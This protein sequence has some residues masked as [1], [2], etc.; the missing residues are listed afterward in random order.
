MKV[1]IQEDKDNQ[2]VFIITEDK[3]EVKKAIDKVVGDAI[4]N[5]S[6]E[7]F[8]KGKAP[9]KVALSKLDQSKVLNESVNLLLPELY[10]Q[11]IIELKLKPITDPKIELIKFSENDGLEVAVTVAEKP[12]ID[13]KN[14]KA[15]I[16]KYIPAIAPVKVANDKTPEQSEEEKKQELRAGILQELVKGSDIKLAG[17]LIEQETARMLNKLATSL[18]KMNINLEDYLKSQNKKVE[19]IRKE[20]EIVAEQNLKSEFILNAIG[21]E[22]EIK[23]EDSEITDEISSAPDENTKKELE[24]PENRWYIEGV[25]FTRKVFDKIEQLYNE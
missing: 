15:T 18:N 19:D 6:V 22:L 24:K 14:Y 25:I 17:L 12:E 8:R 1:N 11:A 20:Y 13:L 21:Q 9:K 10:K 2:K 23:V 16:K 4:Q 7:G 5:I 3:S